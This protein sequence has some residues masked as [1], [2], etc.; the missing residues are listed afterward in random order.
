M[1]FASPRCSLPSQAATEH[2][3]PLRRESDRLARIWRWLALCSGGAI[4]AGGCGDAA[5]LRPGDV[6]VY[7][8]PKT[9]VPEPPAETGTIDALRDPPRAPGS[10][11][12]PP[13]EAMN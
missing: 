2:V 12:R 4:A 3:R 6:R 5:A 13:Q 9:S 8:V 7:T 10:E 1:K 11:S